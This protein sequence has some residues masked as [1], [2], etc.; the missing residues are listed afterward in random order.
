M[1]MERASLKFAI[2]GVLMRE[3][4]PNQFLPKKSV[5]TGLTPEAALEKKDSV[6]STN[7][8]NL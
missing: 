2:N 5:K 1:N 4:A 6:V 8:K 3:N 7:P